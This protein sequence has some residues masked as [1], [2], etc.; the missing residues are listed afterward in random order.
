[1]S[2]V[3]K[4][5]NFISELEIRMLHVVIL[6]ASA[7][8]IKI[9]KVRIGNNMR[10]HVSV[11]HIWFPNTKASSIICGETERLLKCTRIWKAVDCY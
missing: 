1:M 3:A 2:L 5:C 11:M 4:S 8:V 6:S 9:N 10:M 7:I